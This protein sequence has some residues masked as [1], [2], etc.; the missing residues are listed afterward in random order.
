M[1]GDE[2]TRYKAFTR[3]TAML[4]G[5]KLAI[6]TLLF[7]RM[8]QLQVIQAD[9]YATLAEDNRISLR[10]LLPRRGRILDR[11]GDPLATNRE[12]FRV[13]LIAEQTGDVDATLLALE[14]FIPLTDLDRQRIRKEIRRRRGFVPITIRENLEWSDVSRIEVHSLDLPG[15]T[16]DVGQS[17]EYPYGDDA[18]H[19][20]G[21]VGPVN[22]DEL[23]GDPLLELPD[24]RIGK[25]GIE[26][27]YELKLRGAAG[28][29]QVEVNAM[30]R[31]IKKRTL[32]EGKRGNNV[33]LTIDM[34]LQR[35]TMQRLTN[36]KSASAVAMD[37]HTGEV[38][39][40][41]SS[42]SFDPNGFIKGLSSDQWKALATDPRA[43]L[44][45]KA[46]SGQYSPG[47]TFKMVV[48]LAALEGRIATPDFMTYCRGHIKLGNAKFHCWKRYGHG[49]LAMRQAMQQSCDVYFYELSK[50]VGIDRIAKMA[51]R[52]GLGEKMD[53]ELPGEKIGLIP[54]KDWKLAV[55]GKPWQQGETLVAGI[56]QGFVLSTPLQL[57]VMAARIGNGGY[58]VKPRLVRDPDTGPDGAN[59]AKPTKFPKI[60]ISPGS[61]RVVTEAMN[62][63]TNVLKGTAYRSR[64]TEKGMEMAGKTGTSQVRRISKRER[65][66][67]VLKNHERPWK[68][69]DHA[70]FVAFAPVK[71][72]RYAIAVVVEHGGSGSKAA[73]P[74]AR[75][76]LL[77]TQ[78]RAKALREGKSAANGGKKGKEI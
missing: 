43:P 7:G 39:V 46:I 25:N 17:R 53:I 5:G 42:P 3:R 60:G 70:L 31:E 32:D 24:F 14:Q 9:R 18:V 55:T 13:Q 12:N 37:I 41:A 75:D 1:Y 26:R 35:Y 38:L 67:R 29:R 22:E 16:I 59:K 34:A 6:L 73:A 15:I 64:I 33:S 57:A 56:G 50:K 23:T 49:W 68:D 77:E 20:L 27:A 65:D 72:P 58:A 10:L 78:K 36:E 71:K 30:G 45:N 74:I 52:L 48:A 62:A 4:A 11:N 19:I 69:R 47:S 2:S 21:Y 54:T 28:T 44:T 66:T 63:V 61:L 51:H 40:L 8:Y 76:I